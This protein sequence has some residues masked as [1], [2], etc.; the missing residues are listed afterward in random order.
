MLSNLKQIV[1]NLFVWLHQVLVVALRIFIA[2]RRILLSWQCLESL[3]VACRLSCSAASGILV[4]QTGFKTVY[5]A[6]Q[7]GFFFK[8][9][10]I[11]FLLKDNCFTIFVLVSAIHPHES[12]IGIQRSSPSCSSLPFPTPSLLSRLHR[13]PV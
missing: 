13:A 5:L 1:F 10:Y 7:A 11:Y 2:S 12:A 6:L 4:P 8:K 9:E 3:V